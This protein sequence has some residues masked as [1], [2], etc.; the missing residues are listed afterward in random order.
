MLNLIVKD[1]LL[2]NRDL[3][4]QALLWFVLI[5]VLQ[6]LGA[7]AVYMGIPVLM[8][9]TIFLS[10]CGFGEKNNV[11]IL[12]S[13]LPVSGKEVVLS[14]YLSALI[15]LSMSIIINTVF[16]AA[17]KLTG[18]SH[19]NRFVNIDDISICIVFIVLYVSIYIPIYLLFGYSKTRMFGNVLQCI[20]LLGLIIVI[21]I[22]TFFYNGTAASYIMSFFSKTYFKLLMC[23]SSSAFSIIIVSISIFLSLKIYINR[24]F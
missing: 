5:V 17:I 14:K 2:L 13:S 4:K 21:M 24:E 3:I 10:S 18:F 23:T 11:D 12:I 1:F 22:F 8:T 20:V 9:L 16:V 6:F 7:S 19:I 15:F